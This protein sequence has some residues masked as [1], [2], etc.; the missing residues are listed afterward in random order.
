MRR[1]SRQR[2]VG[3]VVP[4]VMLPSG[5]LG[6]QD[7]FTTTPSSPAGWL[8]GANRPQGQRGSCCCI[9]EQLACPAQAEAWRPTGW[10]VWQL[11]S[12]VNSCKGDWGL[13]WL[14]RQRMQQNR[15]AQ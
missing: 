8:A 1:E 9:R 10:P 3:R 2:T 6:M 13:P 14:D 11:N 5:L 12:G 7:H 4:M 15:L